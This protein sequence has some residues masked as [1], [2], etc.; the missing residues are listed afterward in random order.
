MGHGSS[1][2]TTGCEQRVVSLWISVTKRHYL[3]GSL[4]PVTIFSN[5]KNLMY[6][7]MPQKLSQWQAR[8]NLTLSQ[9]DLKLVHIPGKKMIQSDMLSWWPNHIPD[10]DTNNEDI[11]LLPEGLF[12]WQID[13]GLHDE[14]IK[15]MVEDG[16]QKE[17]ILA[18]KED[19]P[20]LIKSELKDWEEQD[21]LLFFWDKCYV[22]D[23][24]KLQRNLV[25]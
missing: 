8:W 2:E 3:Q 19:G 20:P 7:W 10:K 22:P 6:F 17:A 11:T 24:L 14:L 23:N 16:F 12:V 21:G 18:L 4:H 15:A 1:I 5:H 25:R 13:L 9:Y